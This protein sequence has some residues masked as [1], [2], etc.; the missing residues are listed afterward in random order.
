M[1]VFAQRFNVAITRAKALLIVVGNPTVLS[2]DDCWG[3]LA[4]STA[5]TNIYLLTNRS[6]LMK[7]QDVHSM[8]T[9]CI[10]NHTVVNTSVVLPLIVWNVRSPHISEICTISSAA[11]ISCRLQGQ[12]LENGEM[13]NKY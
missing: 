10:Q 1:C 7:C 11:P 4:H 3:R 6:I 2:K 8:I 13:E 5:F 9:N 12:W